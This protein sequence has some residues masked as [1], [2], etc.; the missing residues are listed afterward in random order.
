MNIN[1]LLKS[2]VINFM[3]DFFK[4]IHDKDF[5]NILQLFSYADKLLPSLSIKN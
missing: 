4:K 5:C 3:A 2:P 1:D